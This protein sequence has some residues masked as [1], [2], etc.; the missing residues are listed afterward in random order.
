MRV[1][2]VIKRDDRNRPSM[3]GSN[4]GGLV[5]GFWVQTAGFIGDGKENA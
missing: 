1:L 4:F 5:G 2:E 3:G